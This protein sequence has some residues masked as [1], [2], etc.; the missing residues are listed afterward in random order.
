[1]KPCAYIAQ[2]LVDHSLGSY[3]DVRHIISESYYKVVAKRLQ[4]ATIR[5]NETEVREYIKDAVLLHDIGKAGEYYQIQF[6]DNCVAIKEDPSFI[7]HEIGSALFFYYD[8]DAKEEI[9]KL[10]SLTVLNH[11][12]AIRG[13]SDLETIIPRNFELSMIK[14]QKYGKILL[15]SL[16]KNLSI[17][18]YRFDDLYEMIESFTKSDLGYLK[19]YNLFLAPVII[20]DSINSKRIRQNSSRRMFVDILEGEINEGATL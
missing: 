12:N 5:V 3:N 15:E 9:R 8:Y 19:L 6:D 4:K 17:R 10:L 20:G 2:S 18:D 16:N 14:L 7:Y 11:L 1:M 13:I